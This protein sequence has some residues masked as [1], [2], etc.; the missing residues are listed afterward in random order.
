MRS[1]GPRGFF[2][3]QFFIG[4][5][6][7]TFLT[8]PILLL[9]FLTYLIFKSPWIELFF[10]QWLLLICLLNLLAGNLLMIYTNMIAIFKRRMYTLITLAVMNPL[11]WL[12]HS[13]AAYKGLGQ[14]ITKPFYWE[15][16]THG[17]TKVH[18][19]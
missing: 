6:V 9:F 1:I 2:G 15:K 5:T 10:P 16:T 3:F 19:K 17:L 13:I 12:L 11:Y 14:L 7:A 18:K 4:G 8:Y